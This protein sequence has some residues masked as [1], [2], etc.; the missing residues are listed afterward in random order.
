MKGGWAKLRTLH[1]R[2]VAIRRW[3]SM[4]TSMQSVLVKLA[5]ARALEQGGGQSSSQHAAYLRTLRLGA[6]SVKVTN[7]LGVGAA[8]RALVRQG[9]AAINVQSLTE[10]ASEAERDNLEMW[11]QGD[12]SFYSD[13][14]VRARLA[15]RHDARVEAALQLWWETALQEFDDACGRRSKSGGDGL[16][17]EGYSE[18]YQR[19]YRV[20]LKVRRRHVGRR[21]ELRPTTTEL[22]GAW[23][24][25]LRCLHGPCF[26]RP[27]LPSRSVAIIGAD[28]LRP[29][30]LRR[31]GGPCEHCRGLGR[32]IR[33]PRSDVPSEAA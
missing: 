14:N 27:W 33:G 18:L 9:T 2:A 10:V 23:L 6:R 16:S 1:A 3:L 5:S 4:S 19:L 25:C 20:V 30:E 24:F 15:L 8:A 32:R 31:R 13:K 22:H 26:A 21:I 12:A 28:R 29:A 17:F 11:Q 7:E